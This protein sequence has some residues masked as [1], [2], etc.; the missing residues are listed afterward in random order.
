MAT[1]P[2][3]VH[4][5]TSNRS[6]VAEELESYRGNDVFFE[7][8]SGNNGDK[9]IE[10]GSRLALRRAGI[11]LVHRPEQAELIVVNGGAGMTDVWKAVHRL[12]RY[13]KGFPATPVLVL[14]STFYFTTTDFPSI[15]AHRERE[16]TLFSRDLTS[17]KT[18]QA[19]RFP[20]AAR[21]EADND[22]AFTLKDSSYVERLRRKASNK[23]ILVVERGDAE[24]ASDLRLR[25][26]GPKWRFKRYIPVGVKRPIRW[27]LHTRRWAEHEGQR[28]AFAGATLALARDQFPEFRRLPVFAADVSLTGAFSFTH[29]S[30]LIADAAVVITTRLH[31]GILAAM[32]GKPT[33]LKAGAGKFP[34]I[35]SI[36]E[37]SLREYPNVSLIS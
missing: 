12:E 4:T 23:H 24:T 1:E 35:R 17:L 33:L 28:T 14:P 30:R 36:Y 8:L 13:T 27:V 9:L 11:H 7:P 34:K 2:E 32:L 22:M 29:F 26:F 16:V 20:C 25:Q 6:T 3:P 18:L 5:A 31:V 37:Y 15:F 19:L 21:L 10:M